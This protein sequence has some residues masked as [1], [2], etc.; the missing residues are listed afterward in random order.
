ML[1]R[2]LVCI[3]V[4]GTAAV[5]YAQ[6]PWDM[7]KTTISGKEVAIEYGCPVLKGRTLAGLLGYLPPDRIWRAGAGAVTLLRTKTDLII[8]GRRIPAGNYGLYMYC[9]TSGDYALVINSELDEP[10]GTILPPASLNREN[11]PFPNFM[12]YSLE[13]G[14]K[15]V[16]RIPMK[17]ISSPRT[18][19]LILSFEPAGKGALL[20]IWWGEQAWTVEFQPA[21]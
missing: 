10:P 16:A 3:M 14:D 13:I 20:K 17:Q 8:S 7:V 5:S 2:F 11:R 12:S 1:N 9:P 19:R 6:E 15:E 18:E 4:F 21:D